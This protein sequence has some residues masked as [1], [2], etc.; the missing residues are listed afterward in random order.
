M[1]T[2]PTTSSRAAI[3]ER[4]FTLLDRGDLHD[5]VQL[6]TEAAE[7]LNDAV[8]LRGREEIRAASEDILV[9]L[10]DM[11]HNIVAAF[12]CGSDAVTIEGRFTATFTGPMAGVQPTGRRA[13]VRL[14]A[15]V[16]FENGLMS[17]WHGYYDRLTLNQQ[18]GIA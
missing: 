2:G 4:W 18:L 1:T 6:F 11:R 7:Y 10:P 3:V 9:S 8:R 16:R 15:V 5:A 13:D 12:D 17:S 14:A